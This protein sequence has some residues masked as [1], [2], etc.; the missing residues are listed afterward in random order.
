MS[1]SRRLETGK[2]Y[3]VGFVLGLIAAP[4][5]A[6]G[7]GWVSTSGARTEA[8]ENAR[9]ET[10]SSICSATAGRLATA[11]GTDLTTLKGYQNRTQRGELV[12]A[13]MADIQVPEALLARVTSGCDRTL[14]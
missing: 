9:I 12:A 13:A 14:A 10:L 8:V 5:V 1:F 7:A 4:A 3:I 11:R 2:P 6:F